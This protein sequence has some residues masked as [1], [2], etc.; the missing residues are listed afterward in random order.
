M[1]S[2]TPK[3]ERTPRG[4]CPCCAEPVAVNEL[5]DQEVTT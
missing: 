2:E 3:I 5:L 4:E 1:R